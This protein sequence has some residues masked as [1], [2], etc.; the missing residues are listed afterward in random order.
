MTPALSPISSCP[1]SALRFDRVIVADWSAASALSP[2]RP[3]S[4]AIWLGE[5]TE[6]GTITTYHRSRHS[7]EASLSAAIAA[8]KT[9]GTSLLIGFDFPM[10]YPAGFAEALTGQTS[11]AAVWAYM[12]SHLSDDAQN[13]NNRFE[14]AAQINARLGP[15]FWGRPAQLA[16]PD[17]P[18]TKQPAYQIIAERRRVETL[19]PRAQP[20]WKLYT[21]GAAGSQGLVGQAMIHRLAPSAAVWPF[22]PPAQVTL[23]EVYPS[24][25]ARAVKADPAQI[26]D[27]AQVRLLARALF[28][29]AHLGQLAPLLKTPDIA[30]EEGWI[31]GA[32]HS[33]AL[34][35]AL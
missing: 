19:V 11:A 4:D 25:L 14:V 15:L 5:T 18:T 13:R 12:A 20:V 27:E 8:A 21:T 30:R 9:S 2:A 23:A 3:S 7:A 29:L 35:A 31:L 28:R 22:Q 32:G 33:A 16:L 34:E 1:R 10:G 26:K 24:L 6:A 17:L